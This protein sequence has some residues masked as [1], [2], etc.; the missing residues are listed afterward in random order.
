MWEVRAVVE[1]SRDKQTRLRVAQFGIHRRLK[2]N[3]MADVSRR[4]RLRKGVK[5]NILE[6]FCLAQFSKYLLSDNPMP[7]I[8][9]D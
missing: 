9:R 2:K 6:S 5:I 4:L 1:S 8:L 7:I 3:K